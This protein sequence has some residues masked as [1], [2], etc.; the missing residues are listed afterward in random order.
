MKNHINPIARPICDEEIN[1][2]FCRQL[3]EVGRLVGKH[4][5][6]KSKTISVTFGQMF[7]VYPASTEMPFGLG[8]RL[9][10]GQGSHPRVV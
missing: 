7:V 8:A 10:C 3:A 9:V 2:G 5:F 1:Q 4:W 6:G